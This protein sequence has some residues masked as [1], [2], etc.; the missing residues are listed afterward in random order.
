MRPVSPW[1]LLSALLLLALPVAPAVA[2]QPAAA[3]S[4]APAAPDPAT[5]GLPLLQGAGHAQRNI[6]HRLAWRFGPQARVTT[7]WADGY[8]ACEVTLPLA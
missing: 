8:Y 3:A 2:Q 6:A 1:F 5:R 4:D 7:G